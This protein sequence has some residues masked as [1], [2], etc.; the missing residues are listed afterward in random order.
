MRRRNSRKR[1]LPEV[2]EAITR[3]S[4]EGT[5]APSPSSRRRSSSRNRSCALSSQVRGGKGRS[6]KLSRQMR[7]RY[8]ASRG[9]FTKG[10]PIQAT[11]RSCL[12]SKKSYF[13]SGKSLLLRQVEVI[14]LMIA[15]NQ[16][17]RS[18]SDLPD[19]K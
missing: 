8:T 3:S 5:Q 18:S 13:T 12:R 15:L 9:N 19:V 2:R 1:T 4:G 16:T 11:D 7:R 6:K 17:C 10:I 14:F